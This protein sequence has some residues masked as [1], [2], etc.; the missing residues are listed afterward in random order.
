MT[1]FKKKK[2]WHMI[3]SG[4]E[5]SGGVPEWQRPATLLAKCFLDSACFLKKV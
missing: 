5:P 1:T 3:D 4:G 2:R